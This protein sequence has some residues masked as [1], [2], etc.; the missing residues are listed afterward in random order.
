MTKTNHRIPF[1][2]VYLRLLLRYRYEFAADCAGRTFDLVSRLSFGPSRLEAGSITPRP[3][4]FLG[5]RI[6]TLRA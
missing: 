6:P 1:M 3:P 5:T 2:T 4:S